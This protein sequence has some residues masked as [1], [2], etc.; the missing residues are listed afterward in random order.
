MRWILLL[1]VTL[2][3]APLGCTDSLP[4]WCESSAPL[5][6]A[7][8]SDDCLVAVIVDY[9]R[10]EPR[11][12]LVHTST[13]NNPV[14]VHAAEALAQDHVTKV[15]GADPPD[16]VDSDRA[17][18]FFLCFLSYELTGD[19]WLVVIHAYSGEVLFAGLEKWA[20]PDRGHDYAL[21]AGWLDPAPL[22]CTDAPLEPKDKAKRTTGIPMGSDA[23]STPEEAWEVARRLNLVETFVGNKAFNV[24][25]VSYAPA[26]GEFDP[27]SSDW[28][29]WITHAR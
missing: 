16:A 11:G 8:T 10:V 14:D 28:L 29:V 20:N 12:F 5:N 23:T 2:F 18:D 4:A 17:G 7:C 25:V 21:P 3:L 26:T 13:Q 1:G 15:L 24:M 19:S 22:Q 6:V 27:R 9:V